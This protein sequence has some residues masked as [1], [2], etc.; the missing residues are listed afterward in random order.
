[1]QLDVLCLVLVCQPIILISLDPHHAQVNVH[2]FVERVKWSAVVVLISEVV[3]C[4]VT[5]Y[6]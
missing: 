3:K 6:L 5:V 4:L 2:R 1:M